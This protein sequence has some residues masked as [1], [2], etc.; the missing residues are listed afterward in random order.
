MALQAA[1]CGLPTQAETG[2]EARED[3]LP[4]L[5]GLLTH[6]AA[7]VRRGGKPEGGR[8]GA[9]PDQVCGVSGEGVGG[10]WQARAAAARAAATLAPAAI[11]T[12][13][14]TPAV[15]A[16]TGTAAAAKEAAASEAAATEAAA[17]A[18]EVK[19]AG[20]R[21]N[22]EAAGRR[23]VVHTDMPQVCI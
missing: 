3:V 12:A 8:V 18:V 6:G 20:A 11:A 14:L 5:G 2:G 15:Q 22:P 13:G 1:A 19:A 23:V 7:E 21:A 16:A 4:V 9:F 10:G 17:T